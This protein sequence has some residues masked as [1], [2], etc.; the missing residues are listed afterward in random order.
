MS[1]KGKATDIN[2]VDIL[3]FDIES[4]DLD[5]SDFGMF[6]TDI[7][8]LTKEC[9]EPTKYKKLDKETKA[10]LK[11]LWGDI[12]SKYWNENHQIPFG[13]SFA[14][15]RKE[16]IEV[17][18]EEVELNLVDDKDLRTVLSD[19]TIIILNKILKQ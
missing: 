6:N 1:K 11:I 3:D 12:V 15:L 13:E 2:D 5:E 17:F 16:L 10:A 8:I 14:R 9:L 7:V 19:N 18:A 4:F